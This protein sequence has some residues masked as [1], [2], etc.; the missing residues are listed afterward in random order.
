[1]MIIIMFLIV[2]KADFHESRSV[3]SRVNK[4]VPQLDEEMVAH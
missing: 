4:V 3:G 1:M 2:I